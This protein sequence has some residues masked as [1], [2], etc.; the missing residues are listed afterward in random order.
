MKARLL[1]LVLLCIFSFCCASARLSEEEMTYLER[2]WGT[3]LV[4]TVSKE[5][6]EEVWARIQSFIGRYSSTEIRIATDYVID[7]Y[8]PRG[9]FDYG[10]HAVRTPKGDDFEFSIRCVG[11]NVLGVKTLTEKNDEDCNRNAHLLAYFALS[12]EELPWVIRKY[13]P[14]RK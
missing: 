9:F 14:L 6:A 5:N 8:E 4:F 10:Y 13:N 3:H 1:I 11:Y 12:G 7:T 2:A